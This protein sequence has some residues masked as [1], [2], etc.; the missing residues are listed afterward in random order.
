MDNF[1]AK[2]MTVLRI[3][4]ILEQHSDEEHPLTQKEIIGLLHSEYGISC[5]RK[6]VGRNL[7]ML[8]EGGFDVVSVKRGSYL[9]SKSFEKPELRV[10][11]DSVLSS[12]HIN[13]KHS[14]DLI[15]KLV[16]LGGKYFSGH[17]KHLYNINEWQKSTNSDFFLNVEIADDAI[18]KGKKISFYYNRFGTDKKLHHTTEKKH[19]VSPYQLLLHNQHYYFIG[20]PDKH[21]SLTPY[22][23]D[24]ITE[25]E[26][27][28]E[29]SFPLTGIEG[30]AGGL[31]LAEIATTLP[32][33]FLEKP[34]KVEIRCNGD[35]INEIID[36]F[37]RDVVILPK[38]NGYLSVIIKA[39]QSAIIHWIMQYNEKVEVIAPQSLRDAVIDKIRKLN[40]IYGITPAEK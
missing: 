22:R 17:F 1:E 31:N 8:K 6:A 24:K 16:A 10:L 23:L 26:M 21:E 39:S 20:K 35:M 30:Y 25:I 11:V 19:V 7:L 33:L 38:Q 14:Q 40:E 2:K 36:W 34:V 15:N 12:R 4:N 13:A 27:L 37:G 18:D 5:E 9:D 3:L 29:I 32:Y 28:D